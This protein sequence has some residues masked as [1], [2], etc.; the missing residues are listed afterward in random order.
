MDEVT[1]AEVS[2][3]LVMIEELLQNHLEDLRTIRQNAVRPVTER[4]VGTD[5]GEGEED[6]DFDDDDF[7]EDDDL[8][9]DGR[10][11]PGGFT[12]SE[13]PPSTPQ[14][15]EGSPSPPQEYHGMYS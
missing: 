1:D 3:T 2:Q 15:R 9:L 4:A 5:G 10:S 12:T 7:D 8:D 6:D 14:T 11:I 13:R